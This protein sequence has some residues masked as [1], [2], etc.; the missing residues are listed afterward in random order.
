MTNSA[1]RHTSSGLELPQLPFDRP[2]GKSRH[3]Q[4]NEIDQRDEE[5]QTH[6]TRISRLHANPPERIESQDDEPQ[7]DK[8]SEATPKPVIHFAP[9]FAAIASDPIASPRLFA[10][11]EAPSAMH[12]RTADA[13]HALMMYLGSNV[14]PIAS[15]AAWRR[16]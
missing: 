9:S 11:A 13:E 12:E 8:A 4:E 2:L 5:E 16:L 7:K 6:H 14:M 15:A 1:R 3:P 10:N